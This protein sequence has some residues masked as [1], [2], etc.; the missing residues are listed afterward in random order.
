VLEKVGL[1][2]IAPS[3]GEGRAEADREKAG[4]RNLELN[5]REP[6]PIS[7]RQPSSSNCSQGL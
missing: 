2:H 7:S 1:R 6:A 5:Q 4:A 3:A